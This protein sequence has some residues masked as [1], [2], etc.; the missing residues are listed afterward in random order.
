MLTT[1]TAIY[2]PNEND[3]DKLIL[4]NQS[5]I[6]KDLKDIKKGTVTII[7]REVSKEKKLLGLNK[8]I[9]EEIHNRNLFDYILVEADGSK[10]KS[11]KAPADHEP[12]IP[13]RTDRVIGLIGLDSIGKKINEENVH[14][15]EIFCNI[16]NSKKEDRITEDKILNL[17]TKN[18]GLF[19]DVPQKSKKYIMLNKADD[20]ERKKQALLIVDLIY[21][22]KLDVENIIVSNMKI[23]EFTKY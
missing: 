5:E 13:N 22:N 20:E 4:Y 23:K 16:T 21:K 11:I 2:Y 10:R 15:P 14:R 3:Y 17:L 12:A 6:L 19:K 9:V 18:K 7:G 1:T 8:E